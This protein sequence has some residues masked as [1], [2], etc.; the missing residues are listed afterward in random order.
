MGSSSFECCF[1]D[2]RVICPQR[3]NMDDELAKSISLWVG[4]SST[5][6]LLSGYTRLFE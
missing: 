5:E 2:N 3:P 1:C 4:I 6:R